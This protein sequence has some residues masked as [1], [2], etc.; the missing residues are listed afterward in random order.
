MSLKANQLYTRAC[1]PLPFYPIPSHPDGVH[2][3]DSFVSDMSLIYIQLFLRRL[4]VLFIIYL[5]MLFGFVLS[6]SHSLIFFLFLLSL[7]PSIKNPSIFIIGHIIGLKKTEIFL[8]VGYLISIVLPL[9]FS[10]SNHICII[11]HYGMMMIMVMMM[12][13][14]FVC[15]C[16]CTHHFFCTS[17]FIVARFI[18]LFNSFLLGSKWVAL[19]T[20]HQT[21]YFQRCQISIIKSRTLARSFRALFSITPFFLEKEKKRY[22]CGQT[23]K[24]KDYYDS[25]SALIA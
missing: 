10:L 22:C 4:V 14:V 16:V 20:I 9:S 17:S 13:A 7:N 1:P 25:H 24:N 23:Q 18:L 2:C 6:L 8:V 11:V 15:V 19:E 3:R 5:C 21:G 12:G